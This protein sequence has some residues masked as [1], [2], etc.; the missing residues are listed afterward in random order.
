MRPFR[1]AISFPAE[2]CLHT[3]TRPTPRISL[4]CRTVNKSGRGVVSNTVKAF[5]LVLINKVILSFRDYFRVA[6]KIQND[7]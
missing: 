6:R 7:F 4:V 5:E 1:T 2:I 3:L